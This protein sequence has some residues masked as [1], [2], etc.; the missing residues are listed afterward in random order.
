[1]VPDRYSYIDIGEKD[2]E[3]PLPWDQIEP[4]KYK[5]WD[6][7]I[8]FEE[9]LANSKKRMAQN[10]N[11]RLIE[12]NAE[13]IRDQRNDKSFPLSFEEYRTEMEN[14]EEQAQ[15]FNKISEYESNLTYESLPYEKEMF[16][17]D[18]ILAEKR[19]RWHENLSSDVYMEEAV[20][21]LEDM[22]MNN[23][24]KSGVAQIKE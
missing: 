11:L 10:E 18:T 3:N 21:V 6:G 22:K 13:W 19:Q 23:I 12:Q 14:N 24:R 17:T 4:A 5:V 8:D 20:N 9:T 15:R 16:T 2:Q 1:M 7:Y